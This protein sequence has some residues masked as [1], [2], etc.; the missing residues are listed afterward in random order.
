MTRRALWKGKLSIPGGFSCGVGLYSALSST[1]KVSFHIVNRKTGH[2]VE[3]RF[4]D[5]ET[6]EP[7]ER[8]DQVRGYR[9]DDGDYVLVENE[10]LKQLVPQSHKLISVKHFIPCE[11]VDKVYFDKPYFL[12]PASD[13]DGEAFRAFGEALGKSGSTAFAETVL[14]RRNRALLIR[15]HDDT[16][17]AATLNYDYEVRTARNAFR[18]IKEPDF[19]EELLDLAGHLIE[20]KSGRFDPAD[21]HDRYNQALMELVEAKIEG[22]ALPK[23]KAEPE[24]K[25]VDLR[26]ALRLSA[27]QS[28]SAKKPAKRGHKVTRKAG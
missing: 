10:A 4:V 8:D 12:A 23:R 13:A 24:R 21:Y 14:F 9:L 3:R 11:A 25:V 16:V 1:E 18:S 15:V 26:E 5:S 22:R 27:K 17:I 6:E 19:D 28:G 20:T 7:V 2:R